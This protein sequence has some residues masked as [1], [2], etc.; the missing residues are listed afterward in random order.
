M[1]V[2]RGWA[3]NGISNTSEKGE[4]VVF[5]QRPV[6]T[7]CLPGREWP[8]GKAGCVFLGYW[9]THT[10]WKNWMVKSQWSKL[11]TCLRLNPSFL[12]KKSS[13]VFYSFLLFMTSL[14]VHTHD[15]RGFSELDS[16]RRLAANLQTSCSPPVRILPSYMLFYQPF[17]VRLL[18]SAS[19]SC[20]WLNSSVSLCLSAI[21]IASSLIHFFIDR[22]FIFSVEFFLIYFLTGYW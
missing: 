8:T 22:Y 14:H 10:F 21:F 12:W 11:L 15:H 13:K 2:S 9:F 6:W 20:C 17:V 16:G 4:K 18:P 1:H 5:W 3:A 19:N 7:S